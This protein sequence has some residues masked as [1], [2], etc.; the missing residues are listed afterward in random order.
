[1]FQWVEMKQA[2]VSDTGLEAKAWRSV[3]LLKG[4]L[5]R[6]CLSW[7]QF[8]R[9]VDQEYRKSICWLAFPN[10]H[11]WELGILLVRMVK[12]IELDV[13]ESLDIDIRN[14]SLTIE[15]EERVRRR[16]NLIEQVGLKRLSLIV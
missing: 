1:M 10:C 9:V 5:L 8:R 3:L 12:T 11:D 16:M 15:L 4:R 7:V 6:F 2:R 14:R 13:L